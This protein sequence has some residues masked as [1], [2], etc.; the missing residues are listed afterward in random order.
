MLDKDQDFGKTILFLFLSIIFLAFVA[1]WLYRSGFSKV[2]RK[3]NS[4]KK[5]KNISQSIQNQ[6]IGFE[7]AK[8]LSVADVL[9]DLRTQE[10]IFRAEDLGKEKVYGSVFTGEDGRFKASI[11][12]S[13]AKGE[14]QIQLW[15][16]KE[17]LYIW[18]VEEEK[19]FAY[20]SN[21]SRVGEIANLPEIGFDFSRRFV[22]NCRENKSIEQ[23]DFLKPPEVRL[24]EF[25]EI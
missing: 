17:N 22:F 15:G 24:P 6:P 18:G 3:K 21:R 5:A 11:Y 7:R 16:D 12:R 8:K 2:E 14:I 13:S 25:R 23:S 10:C 20:R 4:A 1:S 9:K 19:E